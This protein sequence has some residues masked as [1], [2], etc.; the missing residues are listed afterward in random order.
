M[1]AA[2]RGSIEAP[3]ANR[4]LPCEPTISEAELK[5]SDVVPKSDKGPDVTI[6]KGMSADDIRWL[7]QQLSQADNLPILDPTSHPKKPK[8]P[9]TPITPIIR[10]NQFQGLTVEET[11]EDNSKSPIVQG[12]ERTA[13]GRPSITSSHSSTAVNHPHRPSTTPHLCPPH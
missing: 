12:L 5:F 6:I 8:T 10:T 9:V 2:F 4:P 11:S 13:A 7:L 3:N 1:N